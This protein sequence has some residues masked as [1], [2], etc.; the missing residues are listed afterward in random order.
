MSTR[1]ALL[2]LLFPFQVFGVRSWP[3][4]SG[5]KVLSS[6]TTD[7]NG[8]NKVL[9]VDGQECR[10]PFR[11]A[12]ILRHQCLPTPSSRLWCSTTSNFD[13]DR[14]WG[15]CAPEDPTTPTVDPCDDNPCANGGLCISIPGRRAF[16]C[17]CLEPF[18]G[19]QCLQ[20][21]CY[22]ELHLRYYDTSQSWGRIHL[23]TVEQ[24]TCV[25]GEIKCERVRYAACTSN[26]CQ[27]EGV[28]RTITSTGEAVC[29]CRPGF[30][31]PHC[32]ITL[33]ADCYW[34]NG[35]DYR[36]T[37][38]ITFSG[39]HC[40]AWNSELLHDELTVANVESAAL[41]GLGEHAF[42]RNPDGDSMPW[43]YTLKNSAI[44]WEYCDIPSCRPPVIF[45]RLMKPSSLPPTVATPKP[46]RPVSCGT[47]HKKRVP[48]PRILGGH[49]TLPGA[50]PWMAAIYFGESF[51]A[52]T[53]IASC[54][55]VSAAHCF[56]GN[57]LVSQV[58][59]VLGQHYFNDTGPNAKSHRIE[60]YIF[61]DRY[62][63]FNPTVHDIVL[64]KLKKENGR[65]AKITP[66][67]RPICLPGEDITFPDYYC[68]D[69]T[70]WGHMYEKAKTYAAQLMQGVVYIVPFEQC[71]RP[72]VYG[73]EVTSSMLCAGSHRC[74]DA[75]QGDSGGP[76]ACTKNGVSFLYGIISWGDGCGRSHKPGVY[77]RVSNYVKWIQRV[78]KSKSKL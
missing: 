28:C 59:V 7:R 8:L 22:E 36:G 29:A 66:F 35:T 78:M 73:A 9:T 32:S 40:L 5:Q 38:N 18:T 12:G 39:A 76:L 56:S 1:R 23:H 67:V 74:V 77:T 48:R 14:Q 68:C 31:G 15:Y 24:C 60:K 3:D 70:G 13:R 49:A 62:S 26:P 53:L 17:R 64:I 42:C 63:V 33:G 65:C 6:R 47:K 21:K 41:L 4:F 10:F 20:E 72:D 52:G 43:C 55:V 27:N 69:I 44:S 45:T 61:P 30:A 25:G 46:S 58:R 2:L 50:H 37:A 16:V 54:W 75:C 57:P 19:R 51:C 71:T 11:Y 34:M